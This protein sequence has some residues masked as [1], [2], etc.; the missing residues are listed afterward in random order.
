MDLME[1]LRKMPALRALYGALIIIVFWYVM[2]ITLRSGIIPGPYETAVEFA[3]LLGGELPAHIGVSFFRIAAAVGLSLAVGVPMGLWAGLNSS[4]DAVV[5]PIAYIL[6]PIPKI[7]FLPVF[8]VILG[9]G[10]VSKIILIFTI[11]IFQVLLSVRDGVKEIPGELFYSVKTLG[12]SRCQIYTNLVLPAVL[13]KIMSSLRTS[14]GVSI[15]VLF[16]GENFATSYGI[17]Y[18]IMNAWAMVD[19]V[20]MFAGILALS[21]MGILIFMFIDFLERKLCP[22]I[23]I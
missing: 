19:Y 22:W 11:I 2:H 12:L 17:G 6:Y 23:Y 10:N 20:G 9:M 4:A 18:F 14:I 16:F 13:P 8:L 5:S 3:R 21:I 15:A 7:A 1:R